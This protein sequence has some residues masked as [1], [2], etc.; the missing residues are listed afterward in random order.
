MP[1][2]V[3]LLPTPVVIRSSPKRPKKMAPGTQNRV[4]GT[5]THFPPTN[6]Y[7]QARGIVPVP[8]SSSLDPPPSVGNPNAPKNGRRARRCAY[9]APS[10]LPSL[11]PRYAG[12]GHRSRALFLFPRPL[13]VHL[14]PQPHQKCTTSAQMCLPSTLT[15]TFIKLTT[16][17]CTTRLHTPIPII[18]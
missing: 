15:P 8:Y 16:H 11:Q 4:P 5:L 13:A 6:I 10:P 1:R 14:S 7:T 2:A 17:P 18:I 9:P 3:L 12:T